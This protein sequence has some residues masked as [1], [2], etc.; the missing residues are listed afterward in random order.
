MGGG[1][2][3]RIWSGIVCDP[4]GI[5]CSNL[6]GALRDC[7][8]NYVGANPVVTL[9]ATP[10]PGSQ[11][12]G[13]SGACAGSRPVCATK[14]TAIREVTAT[15]GQGTTDNTPV[16]ALL[17][18]HG[19]N[20]DPLT[21]NDLVQLDFGNICP[22]IVQG[23]IIDPEST[24]KVLCYRLRFGMYDVGVFGGR[25]GLEGV[26]AANSPPPSSGDFSNF[27]QLG[28][29]VRAAV[30][31][32]LNRHPNAGIVLLGHSRGGLAARD[33][34]QKASPERN[35]VVGLLTTGTPHLGSPL[36]RVYRYLRNHGRL[37]APADWRVV[38]FLRG[39]ANCSN[40]IRY[41]NPSPLDLRR[42]T[43]DDLSSDSAWVRSI[44]QYIS[45][46]PSTIKYG[47]LYYPLLRLGILAEI[48][49]QQYSVFDRPGI[50]DICVQLTADGAEQIRLMIIP[51]M[52]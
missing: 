45:F 19:M 25:T 31:A 22:E 20:S 15:F 35:K 6:P 4:L 51:V 7:V 21:W 1:D 16:K 40:V 37:D 9:F 23:L 46:L 24:T 48:L 26:T 50:G 12:V 44:N 52:V 41:K 17:L 8:E 43:I 28:L 42:P 34:L 39:S 36:G 38:D 3:R 18:L 47:Q 2:R 33:F 30:R 49:G 27:D 11:F 29:E 10:K 32:I 13:W 14:M 5:N